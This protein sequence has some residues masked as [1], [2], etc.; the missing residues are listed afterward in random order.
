MPALK[1]AQ[2]RHGRARLDRRL[3]EACE[4]K[5]KCQ[6]ESLDYP[7]HYR[8]LCDRGGAGRLEDFDLDEYEDE[9]E[10]AFALEFDQIAEIEF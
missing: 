4:S 7:F 9:D 3:A 8:S 5:T 10:E 6:R 2:P 1:S